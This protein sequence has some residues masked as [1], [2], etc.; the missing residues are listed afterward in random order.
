MRALIDE[1]LAGTKQTAAENERMEGEIAYQVRTTLDVID[2]NETI[3]AEHADGRGDGRAAVEEQELA[4][5]NAV[6][7]RAIRTFVKADERG[8]VDRIDKVAKHLGNAVATDTSAVLPG[9]DPHGGLGGGRGE[10]R[11]GA[12]GRARPRLPSRD[13]SRRLGSSASGSGRR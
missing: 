7:S 6:H 9:A 11:G 5:S 1:Q 2:R 3:I 8:E 10:N 4:E 12:R 13:A